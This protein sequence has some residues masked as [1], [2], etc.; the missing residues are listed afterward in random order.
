MY[1]RRRGHFQAAE[2]KLEYRLSALSLKTL[3]ESANFW[4]IPW[5]PWL[6]YIR[7]EGQR[8]KTGESK[9]PLHI[10]P[11]SGKEYISKNWGVTYNVTT[12]EQLFHPR[13]PRRS[14][15]FLSGHIR[16]VRSLTAVPF[17]F[18]LQYENT[19]R[20]TNKKL[21]GGS[22]I[23]LYFQIIIHYLGKLRQELKEEAWGRNQSLLACF[24]AHA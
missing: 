9:G 10:S 20:Q 22:I 21:R 17:H 14:L 15:C 3:H 11:L 19:D 16:Y 2:E 23:I 13:I 18:L 5:C 12:E 1:H 6:F 24:P 7:W 4:Q 8:R